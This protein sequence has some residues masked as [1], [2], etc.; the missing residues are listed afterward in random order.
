M[1]DGLRRNGLRVAVCAPTGIA[2]DN[3][4]GITLDSLLQL[5][6]EAYTKHKQPEKIAYVFKSFFCSL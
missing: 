2:A 6:M 5:P 4:Q 3:I 1:V